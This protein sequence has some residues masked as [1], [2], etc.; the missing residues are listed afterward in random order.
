MATR[1]RGTTAEVRALNAYLKLLRAAGS[2]SARLNGLLADAGV[3][4]SQ[5]AVLDA[6]Y[7][8][9][10]MHQCQLAEKLQRT[11]GNITLVVDNLEK[12]GLVR[13]Q[14]EAEDRRFITVHLT[15]AGQ[16]LVTQVLPRHVANIV[17]QLAVLTA[18]EQDELG[19]LCRKL[20]LQQRG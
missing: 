18:A 9:G 11:G 7:H 5:F 20:G 12:R 6:L 16:R 13:R 19:R 4:E 15:P 8:L 2:T 14:R 3:T 1:Y 10:A 17:A